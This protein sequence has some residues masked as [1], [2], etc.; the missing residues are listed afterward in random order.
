MFCVNR[1]S[2]RENAGSHGKAEWMGHSPEVTSEFYV[3]AGK[4][5]FAKA[6]S[7]E[8]S[9]VTCSDSYSDGYGF[10]PRVG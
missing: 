7:L 6:A 8:R 9:S 5:D 10:G 1:Q 3:R 4:G 2:W